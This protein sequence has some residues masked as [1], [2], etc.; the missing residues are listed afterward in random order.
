MTDDFD[1]LTIDEQNDFINRIRN[2]LKNSTPSFDDY[3]WDGEELSV[4]DDGKTIETYSYS[5]LKEIL[6]F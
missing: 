6:Y 5:D 4:I 3:F 2:F 1:L